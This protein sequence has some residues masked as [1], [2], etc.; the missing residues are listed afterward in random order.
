M[1][2]EQSLELGPTAAALARRGAPVGQIGH[3]TRAVR[4]GGPDRAIGDGSARA[5][6]HD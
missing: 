5:H 2:D 4:D 1:L 6:D 3:R